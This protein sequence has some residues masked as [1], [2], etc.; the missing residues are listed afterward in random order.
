VVAPIDQ[1]LSESFPVAREIVTGDEAAAREALV[2]RARE[3][4]TAAAATL[5]TLP[6]DQRPAAGAHDPFADTVELAGDPAEK[7]T[8]RQL[9]DLPRMIIGV[10]TSGPEP[11]VVF[12]G[13]Y[14]ETGPGEWT[15][16]TMLLPLPEK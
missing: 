8:I 7:W 6:S 9:K 3:K 12:W 16:W 13:G 14:D 15:T 10:A 11:A 1:F 4:M 5:D 2:R